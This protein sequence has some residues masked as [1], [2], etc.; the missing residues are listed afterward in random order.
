MLA[1]WRVHG[2]DELLR[3]AWEQG[4]VLAGSSAGMIC[5]FE[6]GVTDSYGPQLD[7]MRDGLGFLPGSAC[8]HYDGEERRRPVYQELVAGGFPPG[9]AADDAVALHYVGTE[10]RG[11][12][13]HSGRRRALPRRAGQRDAD[14]AQ[15]PRKRVGA[16]RR[17][18]L[19]R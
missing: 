2:F 10:L 1:V 5:W 11:G 19:V 18:P 3:E 4:V 6:A 15:D 12:R 16:T 9:I 17:R 13:D 14:R 8:P 7:G